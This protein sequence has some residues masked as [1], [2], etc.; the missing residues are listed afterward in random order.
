MFKVAK[1]LAE[2]LA[3]IYTRYKVRSWRVR[4]ARRNGFKLL[5]KGA[6]R[7]VFGHKQAPKIAFKAGIDKSG[8][9][10]NKNELCVWKESPPEK[11]R[12]L[13]KAHLITEKPL[14]HIVL[15]TTRVKTNLSAGRSR[16]FNK[17]RLNTFYEE[18]DEA[19]GY[20]PDLHYGNIGITHNGRLV[21]IDYAM[22]GDE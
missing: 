4:A 16:S 11:R 2:T 3:E 13:I 7:D 15:C 9:L 18:I 17:K 1:E 14:E 5:G 19:F 20:F 6:S 21:A 8:H 10:D 12:F 22:L